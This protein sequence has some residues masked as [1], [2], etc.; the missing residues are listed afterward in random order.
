M[1]DELETVAVPL[2]ALTDSA[3]VPGSA[4]LA[5]VNASLR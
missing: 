1:H 2:N 4:A 5:A 3:L